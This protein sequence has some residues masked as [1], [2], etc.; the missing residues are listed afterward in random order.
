MADS[1]RPT[2]SI[3]RQLMAQPVL[4]S[5]VQSRRLGVALVFCPLLADEC[6]T[7]VCNPSAAELP[8]ARE[9]RT[10]AQ[11]SNEF[12]TSRRNGG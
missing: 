5:V 11:S 2:W 7:L 1:T 12:L 8:R 9:R 3:D 6:L 4:G 10:I